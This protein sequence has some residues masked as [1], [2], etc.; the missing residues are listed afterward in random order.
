MG[1]LTNDDLPVVCETDVH[2]TIS[3][4]ILQAAVMRRMPTFF[5][6][7]TIRHPQNNNGELLWHCGVFPISLRDANSSASITEPGQ[8][9]FEIKRGDITLSRFDGDH[10]EYSLFMGHA[11]GII[12]PKTNGTFLWIEVND[13]PKWEGIFIKGPYIHHVAGV[14]SKVALIL[15]A[16]CQYIPGL[17]PDPINPI[18]I[19]IQAYLRGSEEI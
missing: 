10:S 1:E 5:A 6:D 19:Q 8:G 3:S 18:K 7:L 15:Y 4:S 9:N 13:W 2:G 16:A 12:D 11:K 17:K 14:H